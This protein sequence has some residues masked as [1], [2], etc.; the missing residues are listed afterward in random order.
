MVAFAQFDVASAF[1]PDLPA[2]PF[3]ALAGPHL[4][5]KTVRRILAANQFLS[6]RYT[7]P[8]MMPTPMLLQNE[9]AGTLAASWNGLD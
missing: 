9:P 4:N 1:I 5:A 8:A 3:P 2:P 7:C 6:M